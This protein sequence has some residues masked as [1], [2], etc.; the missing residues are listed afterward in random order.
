M[1]RSI[2]RGPTSEYL[3]FALL[4]AGATALACSNRSSEPN[5]V[6]AN[7]GTAGRAGSVAVTG[8]S[9]SSG[10]HHVCDVAVSVIPRGSTNRPASGTRTRASSS[11]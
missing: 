5:P 9:G 2:S 3:R 10:I 6:R 8:G 4:A 1:G 11:A 7:G